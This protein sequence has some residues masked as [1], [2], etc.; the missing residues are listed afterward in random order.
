VPTAAP[1][2]LS[3]ATVVYQ[4][5]VV[6]GTAEV[7]VL[8]DLQVAMNDLAFQVGMETFPPAN[9][10]SRRRRLTV[11]VQ[12]PTG[13]GLVENIGTYLMLG[14]PLFVAGAVVDFTM[15]RGRSHILTILFR[16]YLLLLLQTVR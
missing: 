15:V 1:P 9:G 3:L 13:F 5:A 16:Y 4:I 14:Q 12:I 2:L 8:S 11:S 7:D 6:P 10:G